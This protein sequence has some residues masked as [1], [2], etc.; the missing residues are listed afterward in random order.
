ME[1]EGETLPSV[2]EGI[3]YLRTINLGKKVKLG[4]RVA[5]IGGGNTAIDCAR[6]ARRSGAKDITIIYRRSRSEMPA[7]E[8][9][10]ESTEKEGIKIE[11]LAA[12][13][14]LLSEKGKLF[15][16]ECI[17]MKLGEPDSGGRPR[18]VPLEKSEFI[19]PVDSVIAATGQVPQTE[20]LKEFGI[21]IN[22]NGIIETSFETTATTIEG[23]FAGGDGAGSRAFV[24]DAIASGKKGAL[25]ISCYLDGVDVESEFTKHRIGDQGSF[26]FQHFIDPEHYPADLTKVV[27]Y[28]KIN[29][30]CFP[31]GARHNN[32]ENLSSKDAVKSFREVVGG[33][34]T[35]HMPLEIYRCFKCGTCT[36]CDLCFLLCPDIS[37]I[38]G[39]DGYSI[40]TDFCKGC[41]QCATTCPRNIIEMREGTTQAPAIGGGK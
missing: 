15:A 12:P 21:S 25:A 11:F 30:L 7:L 26:S 36:H 38:K 2:M 35:T 8:D 16:I 9:D 28:D 19:V 4:K 27:P 3:T 5:V 23:I 29:T 33:I 41:S 40:K 13:R 10:V 32:P 31:G 6:T 24:A 20:W 34:D 1:I 37:I 39:K 14:R 17:R 18:P 22:K